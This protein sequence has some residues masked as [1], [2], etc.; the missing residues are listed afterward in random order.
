MIYVLGLIALGIA[1]C[2]G[3]ILGCW[4]ELARQQH[5]RSIAVVRFRP[6]DDTAPSGS[7]LSYTTINELMK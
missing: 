6:I 4:D 7:K 3:Y 2:I 5:Y 1:V